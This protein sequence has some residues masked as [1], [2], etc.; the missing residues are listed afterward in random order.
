LKVAV[1]PAFFTR[2]LCTIK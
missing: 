2:V 1:L